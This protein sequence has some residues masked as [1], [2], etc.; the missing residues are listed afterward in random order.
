M[1]FEAAPDVFSDLHEGMQHALGSLLDS[2]T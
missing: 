2:L 1:L